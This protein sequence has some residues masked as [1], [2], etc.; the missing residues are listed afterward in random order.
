MEP[1]EIL[2][3]RNIRVYGVDPRNYFEF[4]PDR[5][6]A[7][8]LKRVFVVMMLGTEGYEIVNRK[9][10]KVMAQLDVELALN[11]MG[12]WSEQQIEKAL[13]RTKNVIDKL[14]SWLNKQ[15]EAKRKKAS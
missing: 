4:T 7:R 12:W 10:E 8:D 13:P 15:L 2:R 3:M 5:E 14:R 1:G 9:G 6:K 11:R